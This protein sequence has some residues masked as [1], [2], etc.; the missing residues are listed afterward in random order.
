MRPAWIAIAAAIDDGQVRWGHE[1]SVGYFSQDHT[2]A[3]AHGT[4]A[5]EWL[6]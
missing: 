6:H 3:I 5:V 1:V 4:T 2:G